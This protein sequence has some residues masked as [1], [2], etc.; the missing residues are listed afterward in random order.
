MNFPE[1]SKRVSYA[2]RHAP[3][4]YG[5]ELDE[6]GFVEIKALI[7]ALNQEVPVN[8]KVCIG[9]ILRLV[10][11]PGKKRHEIAD[12]KIKALYGHS[13]DKKIKQTSAAPPY[14]LYHGTSHAA[15][16]SIKIYGLKPMQRQYVH[17]AIS[18]ELA[19]RVGERKDRAPIVLE[20]DAKRAYEEGTAFYRGSDDVWLSDE[21]KPNYISILDVSENS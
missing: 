3:A 1:L 16:E 20:I 19:K 2:L 21:I 5:L 9:D 6:N 15:C 8:E 10:E 17:L 13:T 18:M 7:T 14:L 11:L 4:E 12:G